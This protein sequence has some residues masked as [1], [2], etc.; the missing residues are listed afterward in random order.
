MA[1]LFISHSSHD[2]GL[3]QE[4]Q[5]RMAERDYH[6]AFLDF[7]PE[8]GIPAGRN[9]ERELHSK[10]RQCSAVIAVCSEHYTRSQWCF[11]EL[12]YAK[13]AGKDIFALRTDEATHPLLSERQTIDLRATGAKR[14]EQFERLW[15]GLRRAGIDP[16]VSG[17]WDERRPPYPGL[18]AFSEQDAPIFFGRD[19]VVE[20]TLSA[21]RRMYHQGA[22]AWLMVLGASG[23]GKSSVVR[24]GLLPRLRCQT[25]RFIVAKPMRPGGRPFARLAQTLAATFA[26]QGQTRDWEELHALLCEADPRRLSKLGEQVRAA[27]KRPEATTLIT[28]DQFEELLGASAGDADSDASLG[29]IALLRRL[30]ELPGHPFLVLGTLRSDF[31]SVFQQHPDLEDLAFEDVMVGP[32]SRAAFAQVIE[33]PA[34]VADIELEPGLVDTILDDTGPNDLALLAFS[35]RELYEGFGKDR[36]LEIEEYREGLGGLQNSVVKKAEEVLA[37]HK[38]PLDERA[39]STLRVALLSLVRMTDGGQFARRRAPWSRLAPDAHELLQR[40]VDARLLVSSGDDEHREL[41][42]AHE[43]LFRSWDRLKGWL[44]EDRAFKEWEGRLDR[45][46]ERWK[47][48]PDA[49]LERTELFEADGWLRRRP[50][51]V[52]PE[53]RTFIRRSLAAN[54]RKRQRALLSMGLLI[55]VLSGLVVLAWR[56]KQHAEA[57]E[58]IAKEQE[59]LAKNEKQHAIEAACRARRARAMAAVEKFRHGDPWRGSVIA[60]EI[61]GRPDHWAGCAADLVN[62]RAPELLVGHTNEVATVAFAPDGERIASAGKDNQVLLWERDAGGRWRP[63]RLGEHRGDVN[64]VVWSGD[65]KT[66]ASASDDNTV[67]LWHADGSPGAGPFRHPVDVRRVRLSRDGKT[68]ATLDRK[69]RV[70]V[71]RLPEMTLAKEWPARADN[72]IQ[73]LA[74]H[75]DGEL[76]LLGYNNGVWQL[77]PATRTGPTR[78]LP[79]FAGAVERVAFAP[80]GDLMV[81][82]DKDAIRIV[83]HHGK[84]HGSFLTVD[85]HGGVAKVLR[86]YADR[87][88]LAQSSGAF[89][90]RWLEGKRDEVPPYDELYAFRQS[91][92]LD[93]DLSPDGHVVSAAED[94]QDVSLWSL[95][96][97]DPQFVPLTGDPDALSASY[98][99]DGAL[100]I[101][102]K[103]GSVE[104]WSGVDDPQPQVFLGRANSELTAMTVSQDGGA[105]AT[106]ARNGEVRVWKLGDGPD[107]SPDEVPVLPADPERVKTGVCAGD[108]VPL[109]HTVNIPWSLALNADASRLLIGYHDGAVRIWDLTD[110]RWAELPSQHDGAVCSVDF[111]RDG[112]QVA[113]GGLDQTARIWP[114]PRRG[115]PTEFRTLTH[116]G[117]I[118]SVAF[119][120][121]GQR[122]ATGGQ[123]MLIRIWELGDE[124]PR[125]RIRR[126]H[127]DSVRSV[128]F[129]LD[130]QWLISTGDDGVLGIT[131]ATSDSPP[132]APCDRGGF[133]NPSIPGDGGLPGLTVTAAPDGRHVALTAADGRVSVWR[134]DFRTLLWQR[135]PDCLSPER[136][137]AWL[138][139]TADQA[140]ASF[141]SCQRRVTACKGTSAEACAAAI[142]DLDS[143]HDPCAS[144]P[145]TGPSA[146]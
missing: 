95:A 26:E 145:P 46:L 71:W 56:N 32:M 11:A 21:L 101:A 88:L 108:P 123:D 122:L 14:D 33:G 3:A 105:F 27:A 22:P 126:G 67:Q 19:E 125:T 12:V 138:A 87:L 23:S 25:D 133:V 58:V 66:L 139:E 103:S 99:P 142:A 39:I 48:H 80:G 49:L 141:E 68:V 37:T 31:L 90:L 89:V 13:A 94:S 55:V 137:V 112:T 97:R 76:L 9:W 93:A 50:D 54:R 69:D 79:K 35:L 60:R 36:L 119:D 115:S 134:T 47:R 144:S 51:A 4:L 91:Y 52:E 29:F 61:M 7:D 120:A 106:A 30:G 143:S 5:T 107:S 117:P 38:P 130:G 40:F 132:D 44:E 140:K 72:P 15:A 81:G 59:R 82:V 124:S 62:V 127:L 70:R 28:I 96:R 65:G 2:N 42:V 104:R 118:Y 41:E 131:C 17:P 113:S 6:D 1:K 74:L 146:N 43:A 109:D 135:V 73:S 53:G 116:E 110:K 34:R 16:S 86:L 45:A 8:N 64:D 111:D 57:Q 84:L 63:R 83:D 75:P 128:R 20:E 78:A 121:S 100:L 92:L 85:P 10:L 98:L 102:R 18:L 114:L 129:S 24:A 136:R 77:H